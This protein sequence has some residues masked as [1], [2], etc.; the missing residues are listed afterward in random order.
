[1]KERVSVQ[2]NTIQVIGKDAFDDNQIKVDYTMKYNKENYSYK[3]RIVKM[4]YKNIQ[5]GVVRKNFA[6]TSQTSKGITYNGKGQVQYGNKY[7]KMSGG[8]S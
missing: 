4:R 6:N 1:M 3:V 2:G 5:I 7:L 8:F